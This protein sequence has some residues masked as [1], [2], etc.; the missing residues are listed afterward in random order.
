MS[1]YEEVQT[2]RVRQN[3][4][5][6]EQNHP[7]I[8]PDTFTHGGVSFAG[9]EVCE[10]YGV[11]SEKDACEAYECAVSRGDVAWAD[12]LIEEL[13][14]A[15]EAATRSESEARAELVQL[16]AVAIAAVECIDRGAQRG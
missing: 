12:V 6:G 7:I 1:V 10:W 4:K 11:P 2:E 9:R 16:A 5:W 3:E 14:E 13:A 8:D 15:L